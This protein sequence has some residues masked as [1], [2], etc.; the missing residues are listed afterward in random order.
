MTRVPQIKAKRQAVASLVAI[1]ERVGEGL[2][3]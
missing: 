1:L 2:I 3:N